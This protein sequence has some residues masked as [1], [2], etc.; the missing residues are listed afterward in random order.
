[1]NH[2]RMW[3]AAWLAAAGMIF[4]F[5][6]R[7][8]A[9]G[10]HATALRAAVVR[11][12]RVVARTAAPTREAVAIEPMQTRVEREASEAVFRVQVRAPDGPPRRSHLAVALV[13][14]VSG[15]MSG[16]KLD[17]ARRAA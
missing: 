5:G 15:S 6:L 13:L 16:N 8:S 4:I 9:S 2:S 12:E 17:N 3:V 14:D 1:M 10:Q 7:P 11:A